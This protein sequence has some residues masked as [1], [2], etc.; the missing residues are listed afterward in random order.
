MWRKVT[1]VAKEALDRIAALY[2]IEK[3]VRGKLPAARL[4]VRQREAVPLLASLES[5]MRST[6]ATVS[7]KSDMAAA[8]NYSLKR[9]EALTRYSLDG[10]I[11]IDNNAAERAM[12]GPVLGR[13]NWLFAGSHDGGER[14]AAMYTLLETAKLNGIDPEAYLRNVLTRIAE[15]PISRITELL[16]WNVI[17]P[18]RERLAA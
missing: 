8:I 6:L 12:K 5:W 16:P 15:H 13:K 18:E 4:A 2:A 17:Q 3:A 9:W 7:A 10:T 1:P 11:E 14:A